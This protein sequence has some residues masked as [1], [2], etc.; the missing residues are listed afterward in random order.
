MTDS[1]T[2]VYCKCGRLIGHNCWMPGHA[3]DV[4]VVNDA[5][6]DSLHE[7]C[8]KCGCRFDYSISERKLDRLLRRVVGDGNKALS[9]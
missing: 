1:S 7:V 9:D 6:V 3:V 4:L 2:P 5:I 8:T